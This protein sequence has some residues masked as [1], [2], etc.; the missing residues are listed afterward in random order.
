MKISAKENIGKINS[1]GKA[2]ALI[3]QILFPHSYFVPH[4]NSVICMYVRMYV[5]TYTYL[6]N[7]NGYKYAYTVS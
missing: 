3:S 5:C 2:N 1:G 7:E 4:S 6:T